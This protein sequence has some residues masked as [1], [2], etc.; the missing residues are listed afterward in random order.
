MIILLIGMC[1]TGKT[2]VMEQLIQYYVLSHRKKLGKIYYHTDNRII[3]LGKYD[4][5]MYQGTD[6]LSMSVMTDV[7][8]FIQHTKDKII[9]AEGDR[10]TNGKF[11]DKTDPLIIK[12][13]DDGVVGRLKRNSTQSDRHLKSIKTRVNNIEAKHEVINSIEALQLIKNLIDNNYGK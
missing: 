13:T 7:D 10:F 3:V 4:G 12:I 2:W 11:I 5:S 6:K 9:I 1:G 8:A